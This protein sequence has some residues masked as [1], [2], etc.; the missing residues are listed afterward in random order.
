M[1]KVL[2]RE[3][4]SYLKNVQKFQVQKVRFFGRD[5]PKVPAMRITVC[6]ASGSIGQPLSL[7]LKQCPY[8]DELALY[9]L[10]GAC[11]VGLELSHVDTKCKVRAYTGKEQLKESL[12]VGLNSRIPREIHFGDC[13]VFPGCTDC[14]FRRRN[15]QEAGNDEG[16]SLQYKRQNRTGTGCR[17]R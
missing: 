9:D 17:L 10:T 5:E 13:S 6:G 1:F 12:K 3:T 7:M 16:R 4:I 2:A 11:G 15:P 14:G 8:I